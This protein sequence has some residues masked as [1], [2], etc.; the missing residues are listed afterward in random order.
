MS[1]MVAVTSPVMLPHLVDVERITR[2]DWAVF[3]PAVRLQL[4]AEDFDIITRESAEALV[5]MGIIAGPTE[6]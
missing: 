1:S 6:G 4:G 3:R 2:V 5:Q